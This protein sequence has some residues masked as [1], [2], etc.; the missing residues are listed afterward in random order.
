LSREVSIKKEKSEQIIS[1]EQYK[2]DNYWLGK[3]VPIFN[4]FNK[5]KEVLDDINNGK[6]KT[7]KPPPI[8]V[9]RI[10][11]IQPLYQLLKEIVMRIMDS[12]LQE[13]TKLKSSKVI[14]YINIM[15]ELRKDTEFRTYKLKQERSFT[16]VFKYIHPSWNVDD[17]RKVI[18]DSGH[19]VTNIMEHQNARH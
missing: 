19:M 15:K 3:S 6:K 18:E 5:L 9:T 11:N 12:N 4:S 16:I 7:V 2:T 14:D 10:T 13:V 8:F 17:I 1:Y